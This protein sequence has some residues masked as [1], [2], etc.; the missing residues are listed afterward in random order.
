MKFDELDAKTGKA[1][2]PSCRRLM[3]DCG[4]RAMKTCVNL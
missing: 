4:W 1:T 2:G 3:L